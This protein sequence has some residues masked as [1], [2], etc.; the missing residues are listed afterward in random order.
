[1]YLCRSQLEAISSDMS[2]KTLSVWGAKIEIEFRN[3]KKFYK[4]YISIFSLCK[5]C[6]KD[7]A[8]KSWNEVQRVFGYAKDFI[9]FMNI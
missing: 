3:K 9:P 6:R 5:K 1:M 4:L 8:K 7:T 2:M